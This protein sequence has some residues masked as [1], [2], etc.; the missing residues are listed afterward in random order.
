M[1]VAASQTHY[2]KPMEYS[3]EIM[4]NAKKGLEHLYNQVRKL[5][6]GNWKLETINKK[7]KDKFIKAINDDLNIP[8]ALAVVQDLL[9]SDLSN[10]DKLTAVL[11]FDKVLGL[12]LKDRMTKKI[13]NEFVENLIIKRNKARKEKNFEESDRLRDEIE[14]LG[15]TVEDSKDG[16]R[17]YKK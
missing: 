9:K 8:Q 5:E 10:K 17:V 2:R 7:Y 13:K 1:P 6:I 12:D 14:K 15:Y 11:D 3:E 16:M 4:K